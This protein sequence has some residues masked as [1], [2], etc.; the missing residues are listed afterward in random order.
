MFAE[1]H[2]PKAKHVRGPDG[3]PL[4]LAYLPQANHKRWTKRHKREVVAAVVGGLLTIEE[5]CSYR[6]SVE[7]FRGWQSAERTGA[8]RAPSG[9]HKSV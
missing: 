9:L 5:A 6:M 4:M 8:S 1:N 7:E 3:R 2:W